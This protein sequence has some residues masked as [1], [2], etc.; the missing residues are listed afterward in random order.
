MEVARKYSVGRLESH[1]VV[2][3]TLIAKIELMHQLELI[4]LMRKIEL[5][6]LPESWSQLQ[7]LQ[8]EQPIVQPYRQQHLQPI[9][10]FE[11]C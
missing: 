2:V 4:E 1:I 3:R 8:R 6:E 10:E 7:N 11:S 9:F 5:L